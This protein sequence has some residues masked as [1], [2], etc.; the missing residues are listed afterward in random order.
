MPAPLTG[1]VA[2]SGTAQ[3]LATT[4]TQNVKAFTLKA[5]SSNLQPAYLGAAGVTTSTGYRLDPGEEFE[6]ERQLG[7]TL[8]E[9][10][11]SDIYVVGTSGDR[12][13]WFASP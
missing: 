9:L 7:G 10:A 11:P 6:Y 5:A 4:T 12:V 1:Q 13:S 3:Q 8:Y 2:L